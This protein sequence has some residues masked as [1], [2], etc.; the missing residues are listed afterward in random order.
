MELTTAQEIIKNLKS[1]KDEQ[2]LSIPQIKTMVDAT[3]AYLS[4]TTLRR[5]FADSSE[6]DSSFDYERTIR[7]IAQALLVNNEQT[8][9]AIIRAQ[10]DTYLAI[11]RHKDEMIESLREQIE[12]L[13]ES[14]E[15][16]CKEYETRME[17]L[18]DQI[19]LKDQRMD[20]K[21]QM[22]EKLLDQVLTCS[23][24]PVE[25]EK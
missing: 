16:R 17:F 20:R 2:K 23:H 4:M 1:V 15:K 18:R 25:K 14:H 12:R 7:P 21:D 8:G 9:S 10:I 13:K 6:T 22:I 5:V 19:E 3:G 24:C 11:C